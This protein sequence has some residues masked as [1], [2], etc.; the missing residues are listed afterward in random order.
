VSP[1]PAAVVEIVVVTAMSEGLVPVVA[2]VNQDVDAE[3]SL[4]SSCCSHERPR[5]REGRRRWLSTGRRPW[6]QEGDR[7]V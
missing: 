3:L 6:R 5:P 4:S 1:V 2:V 7:R